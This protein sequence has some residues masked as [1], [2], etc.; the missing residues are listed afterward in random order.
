MAF[1]GTAALT[2]QQIAATGGMVLGGSAALTA[3]DA[4]AATGGMA[5]G[6]TA[7]LT[8]GATIIYGTV[9]LTDQ[10][11][12]TITLSDEQVTTI[13]LSDEQV[14]TITLTITDEEGVSMNSFLLGNVIRLNA[15]V[16]D[17]NLA[18]TDPATVT[19]STKP[20]GGVA[21]P[22]TPTHLSTG[23]YRYDY[24]PGT[25]GTYAV[26]VET[27]NPDAATEEQFY[28]LPSQFP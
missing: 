13:T 1:S 22:V 28:I 12:T 21:T 6:G 7:T 23:T 14:T 20:T 15:L 27:L 5:F 10:Q 19:V 9:S 18:L 4:L 16:R 3:T 24:K 17:I 25:S 2:P 26:R 11:V 8:N